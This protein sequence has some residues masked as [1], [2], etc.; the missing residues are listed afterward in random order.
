M[1]TQSLFVFSVQSVKGKE[2]FAT[3]IPKWSFY[4]VGMVT[5]LTS[6]DSRFTLHSPTWLLHFSL[7]E[8]FFSCIYSSP[9]DP[10]SIST[11]MEPSVLIICHY[12]TS[13]S[14]LSG[15][16]QHLLCLRSY[17]SGI[18]AGTNSFHSTMSGILAGWLEWLEMPAMAHFRPHC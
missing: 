18:W 2:D 4:L 13:H 11:L 14:K 12:I 6:K 8:P 9:L 10:C 7:P 5:S 3:F 15:I 1:L 17:G 16:R